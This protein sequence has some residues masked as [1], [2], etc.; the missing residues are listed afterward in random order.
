[1]SEW[2]TEPIDSER[3]APLLA[4]IV[5]SSEDAIVSKDL[6][7]IVKTWNKAAEAMFQYTAAEM[8]GQSIRT[9]IP[10]ERQAEEDEVLSKIRAGV[11]VSHFETVRQRK[12]GSHV[13]ISLSVS[14]VKAGDGRIIGASK[15]A[16]DISVHKQLMRELA[17]TSRV[18][19]E[20]LAT[21]SH[22]LRTPLNA[23]LGYTQ[24]LRSGNLPEERRGQVIEIIERNAQMLS[25]LVSDVLDVSSV[26]TGKLRLRLAGVDL[27]DI[28]ASSI[29]IVQPSVD[30]KGLQVTLTAPETPLIVRGDADRLHQVF[31]NLLTNAVKF[32]PGGGRVD[33][34]IARERNQARVDVTD[35]GIGVPPAFVQRLFERF[36]QVENGSQRESGGLG[37]GLSLVR[38]FVEAHGGRASASSPGEGQG[39][40]FTVELPLA[41]QGADAG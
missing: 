9:I 32:T 7:G 23:V 3:A 21:L 14:P 31:W 1:M 18:K 28:V 16:R 12:D 29:E 40:T 27:R 24:M 4:A 8:V 6:N 37:L 30:A 33:V 35:T 25:Q 10:A 2:P 19:D 39:S 26:V 5:D 36:T 41:P 17:E 20:F 34:T 11:P 13:E 22:E 15:I 38:Y